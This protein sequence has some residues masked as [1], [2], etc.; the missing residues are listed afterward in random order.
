MLTGKVPFWNHSVTGWT[1]E[2]VI[3][4][5]S[6]QTAHCC[7]Y[8]KKKKSESKQNKKRVKNTFLGKSLLLKIKHIEKENWDFIMTGAEQNS[9]W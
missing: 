9:K 5:S 3:M 6:S 2:T 8:H 1:W 7:S 4:Q